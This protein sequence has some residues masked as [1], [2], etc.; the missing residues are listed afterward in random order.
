[1]AAPAVGDARVRNRLHR[2]EGQV[3]GIQRMI[4][5]GRPLPDILL[6]IAAVRSALAGAGRELVHAQARDCSSIDRQELDDVMRSVDAL[7]G[8]V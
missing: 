8:H 1:M 5:D 4:D 7:I 2:I 3:R 6:Q